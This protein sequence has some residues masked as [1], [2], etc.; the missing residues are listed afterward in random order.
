M[1]IIIHLAIVHT[2]L[3]RTLQYMLERKKVS[4]RYRLL[5]NY[6]DSDC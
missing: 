4:L 3:D 2:N 5:S 1:A 6:F